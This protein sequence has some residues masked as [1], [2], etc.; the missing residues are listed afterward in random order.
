MLPDFLSI[1]REIAADRIN[2]LRS[3]ERSESILSLFSHFMQ[4]E[5][6][7]FTIIQEDQTVRTSHYRRI[8][9]EGQ[10]KIDDLLSTGT[11][12]IRDM[13]ATMADTMSKEQVQM[14][15]SMMKSATDEAGTAVHA[16]GRPFSAELFI[17]T[18]EKMELTFDDDGNWEMPTLVG[19]PVQ[20]A[21]VRAELTRLDNTPDLHARA[22]AIVKR[23]REAWLAREANRTLVD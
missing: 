14:F 6:D 18:I 8:E 16:D 2:D 23:K 4:H 11:Q 21:R 13:L 1:K 9:V 15:E 5:G 10:L 22:T 3:A 7:R 19:H 12:A 17:E 20:A